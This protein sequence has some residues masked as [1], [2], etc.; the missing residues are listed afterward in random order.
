MQD[1]TDP[2]MEQALAAIKRVMAEDKGQREAAKA[3]PAPEP[4]PQPSS[5]G[6][7]PVLELD[8]PFI[9]DIGLPMVD[10]TAP[11]ID[12][13]YEEQVGEPLVSE[14]TAETTRA[15]LAELQQAASAP[16]PAVASDV[17]P[18]EQMVRDMMRPMLKD[19]LDEHLP[20]VIEEQVKREIGRITGQRF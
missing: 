8:Q 13:P 7:E 5:A 3:A 2:S 6:G 18:F 1:Q 19:W 15:K 4:E 12:I 16:A 20:R 14:V 11:M 17:N 10:L 9:E